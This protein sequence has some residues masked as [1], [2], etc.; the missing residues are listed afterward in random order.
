MTKYIFIFIFLTLNLFSSNPDW[1]IV[2]YEK[3][4]TYWNRLSDFSFDQKGN[5]W[6]LSMDFF[7]LGVIKFDGKKWY[8]YYDSN[9]IFKRNGLTCINIDKDNNLWFKYNNNH[10]DSGI[11]KYDGI[12]PKVIS[13]GDS[14]NSYT[15]IFYGI[16]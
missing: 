2:R 14:I 1:V 8:P 4:G 11:V 7:D 9:A 3:T 12:A 15:Y 16:R 6:A 13:F 10:R 5:L